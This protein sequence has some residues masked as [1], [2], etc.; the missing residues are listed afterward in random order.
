MELCVNKKKTEQV[1]GYGTWLIITILLVVP[2]S[3]SMIEASNTYEVT[4]EYSDNSWLCTDSV[5]VHDPKANNAAWDSKICVDNDETIYFQISVLFF[6]ILNIINFIAWACVINGKQSKF[7]IMW[8]ENKSS[9]KIKS[10]I[11]D[12]D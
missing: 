2:W 9:N 8:C 6:S 12:S 10:L 7:N 1:L 3:A 11:D 5:L 4:S